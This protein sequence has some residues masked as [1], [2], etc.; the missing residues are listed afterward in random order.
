MAIKEYAAKVRTG[1]P[2]VDQD[3]KDHP[4]WIDILPL[5]HRFDAVE[6]CRSDA[7]KTDVP[8]HVAQHV[9]RSL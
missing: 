2:S 4:I 7:N 1:P 8:D 3:D 9:G 6:T 5:R